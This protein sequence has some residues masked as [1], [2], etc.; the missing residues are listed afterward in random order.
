MHTSPGDASSTFRFPLTE[1]SP[2]YCCALKGHGEGWRSSNK[3]P[4]QAHTQAPLQLEPGSAVCS[5]ERKTQS[6]RPDALRT[7]VA[8]DE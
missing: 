1:I 4:T 3:M 7:S 5:P 6:Q 2:R 8:C